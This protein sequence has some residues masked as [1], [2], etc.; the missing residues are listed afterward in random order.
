MRSFA[1]SEAGG[2]AA[3]FE[4]AARL[5]IPD[6]DEPDFVLPHFQR[7]AISGEDTSGVSSIRFI[8]FRAELL[9]CVRS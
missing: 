8:S 1:G 4:E 6:D 5:R 9:Q 3:V 2:A 7:V